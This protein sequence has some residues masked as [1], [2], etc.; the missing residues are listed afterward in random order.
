MSHGP[1]VGLPAQF[2]RA[3]VTH[4]S[5]GANS[6]PSLFSFKTGATSAKSRGGQEEE[7]ESDDDMG[8]GLFDDAPAGPKAVTPVSPLHSLISLQT[9]SGAWE[10]SDDLLAV[11]MSKG[12][13]LE[14][15]AAFVSEQVMATSLAVAY[16]EAQLADS[17]DV[18]EMVVEKAKA[19]IGSQVGEDVV[20]S[21]V[22]KA[23]ELI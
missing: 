6:Q 15:D 2:S 4:K 10:W 21:L 23:K 19:W 9:F 3:P 13:K 1:G 18:W 5:A 20:D 22:A 7:E 16:M 14:F 17:K 11:V 8:Y 12:K